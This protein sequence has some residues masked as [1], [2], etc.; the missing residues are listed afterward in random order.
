MRPPRLAKLLVNFVGLRRRARWRS[1]LMCVHAA[2][3]LTAEEADLH[4]GDASGPRSTGRARIWLAIYAASPSALAIGLP[5]LAA[6]AADRPAAPVR[7]LA[8]WYSTA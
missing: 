3:R 4:P 6:G 1:A 7:P 8:A 5:V 2:G